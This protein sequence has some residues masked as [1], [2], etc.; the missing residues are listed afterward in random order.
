MAF[1]HF[2]H[3]LSARN[4]SQALPVLKERG[5]YK[6]RG[7]EYWK[8]PWSLSHKVLMTP[9]TTATKQPLAFFI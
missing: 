1:H 3:I 4:K 6:G 2:C 9:K 8:P 5:L 7:G